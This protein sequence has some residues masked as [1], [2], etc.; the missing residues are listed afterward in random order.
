MKRIALFVA[1]NI[2]V[3]IVIAVFVNILGL[4]KI[5]DANG[6]NL[7]AL[8]ILS[9][10]IGFAGAIISLLI[11]KP[12][13]KW[14]TGAHV[15][16]DPANADERWLLDTVHKLS[17]RAGVKMPE[18]AVYEGEANAFATGAF[19]NSA[20]V[21]VSTGLLQTMNHEEVEAVLAHEVA[22]VANGDMVTMTLIQ[23]VVNTFVVFLSR[24]VGYVVDKQIN[25]D[26]NGQG[27]GFFVTSIVCQV[28]FGVLASMIVAWFSRYREFRADAGAASYMGQPNS[29]ISALETLGRVEPGA[30][31]KSIQASGIS[32]KPSIMALFS[33]HPPME[34]RIKA[35]QQLQH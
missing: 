2:A 8:L 26:G 20:L 30:L 10:I 6:L 9:A 29:M 34:A 15:I 27:I 7:G 21:A 12:M 23:G 4:G 17:T 31:P 3:L 35:L 5:T 11:S 18:V 13:A 1:T 24:I 16:T 28:V 19:K 32:D 14:Q 25:R 33:T 22:H